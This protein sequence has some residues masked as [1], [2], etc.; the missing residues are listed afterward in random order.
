MSEIDKTQD[1]IDEY[2]RGTMSATERIIFE[3]ELRQN[4][5]LR[6]EVEVQA[7]ISDA[8][9]AV[10]LKQLLQQ[11]EA[12]MATTN[13]EHPQTVIA[14]ELGR[15]V[16]TS[17]ARHIKFGRQVWYWASAAAAVAL[18]FFAGNEWRQTSRIKEFGNEYYTAM[19]EPIARDGNE[20]D[21][22]ITTG[23]ALIGAGEYDAADVNLKEARNKITE[24]LSLPI[25][26]EES[27]YMHKVLQEKLYD[28]EW[29]E[30]IILM[31]KGKYKKAKDALRTIAATDS[32]YAENAKS[33]L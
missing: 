5:V 21:N 20:I 17:A 27:E 13:D 25:V 18:F 22:L 31:K 2:I 23:Y 7:S 16:A 12:D 4:A 33:I 19:A 32:P 6:Q 26:D 10:H 8:V 3:G 24:G 9:Q 1:R 15:N 28:V 29:Y 11:I 14:E 30:A